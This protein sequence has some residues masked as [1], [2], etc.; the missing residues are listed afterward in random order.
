MGIDSSTGTECT[1]PNMNTKLPIE[2]CG[3]GSGHWREQNVPLYIFTYVWECWATF[4]GEII[5]VNF[6]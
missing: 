3:L 5:Y 1:S 6:F 2:L 4:L